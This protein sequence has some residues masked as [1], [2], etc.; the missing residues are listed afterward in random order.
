VSQAKRAQEPFNIGHGSMKENLADI[1]VVR[2]VNFP[3]HNIAR[4]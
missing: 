4:C 2:D 3:L 1:R